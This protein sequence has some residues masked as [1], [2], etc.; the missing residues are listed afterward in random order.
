MAKMSV[1]YG[2]SSVLK[3]PEPSVTDETAVGVAGSVRFMIWTPSSPTAVTAAYVRPAISKVSTPHAV[4]SVLKPSAPSV[5][6]ETAVGVAG[7]VR[8]IIWTPLSI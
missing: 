8:L 7:S 4:L 6:D 5:T 2:A 1:A 3:P